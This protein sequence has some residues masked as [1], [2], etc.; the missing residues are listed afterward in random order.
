LSLLPPS[1]EQ[2][3]QF[4]AL[5]K[6]N[7]IMEA[8]PASEIWF[9]NKYKGKCPRICIILLCCYRIAAQKKSEFQYLYISYTNA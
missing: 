6:A 1:D 5:E 3:N 8:E 9:L 7:L 4:G 2:P